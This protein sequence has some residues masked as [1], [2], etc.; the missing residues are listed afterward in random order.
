MSR[1]SGLEEARDALKKWLTDAEV[2]LAGDMQLH[3]TLD[4][5]RAQLQSYRAVLLD[6]QQHTQ[7]LAQLRERADFLRETGDSRAIDQTLSVLTDQHASVLKRV[8]VRSYCKKTLFAQFVTWDQAVRPVRR[9]GIF[10]VAIQSEC[11]NI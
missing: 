8:Q 7:Q 1:W 11:S 10:R 5:K 2:L 4:E 3:T 6:A 9:F